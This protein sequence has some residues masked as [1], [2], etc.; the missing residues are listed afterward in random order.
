MEAIRKSHNIFKGLKAKN[1]QSV[2][3]CSVKTSFMNKGAIKMFTDEGKLREFVVS[4][5][6]LKES[7]KEVL[8]I[9]R[10]Y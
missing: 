8:Q 10:K 2:I 4:R 5:L 1:C 7:L 9:E 6:A 3:L